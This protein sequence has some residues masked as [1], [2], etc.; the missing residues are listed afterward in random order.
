MMP[1]MWGDAIEVPEMLRI[2]LPARKPV[3]L[4][5]MHPAVVVPLQVMPVCAELMN[6]PGAAMSGLSRTGEEARRG[7]R[8][9]KEAR[10]SAADQSVTLRV[11]MLALRVLPSA[12]VTITVGIVTVSSNPAMLPKTP[13]A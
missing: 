13:A 7:P 10:T 4:T 6:R 12:F 3:A 5:V 1:A 2:W 8:E 9:E 11:A